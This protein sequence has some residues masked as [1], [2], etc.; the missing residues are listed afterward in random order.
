MKIQR[1]KSH[2]IIKPFAVK[3]EIQKKLLDLVG[4]SN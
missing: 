3:L 1:T 4:P 2:R